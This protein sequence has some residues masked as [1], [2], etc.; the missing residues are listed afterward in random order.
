MSGEVTAADECTTGFRYSGFEDKSK[1]QGFGC[2]QTTLDCSYCDSVTACVYYQWWLERVCHLYR[3]YKHESTTW[4]IELESLYKGRKLATALN[5]N[6]PSSHLTDLMTNVV[7]EIPIYVTNFAATTYHDNNFVI[8]LDGVLFPTE[9]S[10]LNMPETDKLGDYQLDLKKNTDTFNGHVIKCDQRNCKGNCFHPEPKIRRV[11][12]NAKKMP[13]DTDER[14]LI[15]N[16]RTIE[17]KT[18]VKGMTTI[19]IGNID[20]VNLQVIPASC[21]IS[22]VSTYACDACNQK[23]YAIFQAY[24]VKQEGIIPFV[25]N[26]TFDRDYLSCNTEYYTLELTDQSSICNLYLPSLNST[27]L[28]NFDYEFLGG[29]DLSKTINSIESASE[30]AKRVLRDSRFWN[31]LLSSF[32]TLTM[33]GVGASIIVKILKLFK[34]QSVIKE[35]N[36]A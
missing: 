7:K 8:D 6:K 9:A 20:I 4:E 32:T 29:L 10:E 21:R 22:V 34:A 1:I 5:V 17:V 30:S 14:S 28:L 12:K 19:M 27:L 2:L 25:S 33:I 13:K 11:Q 31:G 35:V 3:V 15:N 24:E 26:C 18:Y 23:P 16:G 36:R